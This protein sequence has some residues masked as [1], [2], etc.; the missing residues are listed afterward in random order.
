LSASFS[1]LPIP[2][3]SDGE[4]AL[5]D[6]VESAERSRGSGDRKETQL[7]LAGWR[8]PWMARQKIRPFRSATAA[9]NV[10]CLAAVLGSKPPL[11]SNEAASTAADGRDRQDDIGAATHRQ[12]P[13][14]DPIRYQRLTFESVRSHA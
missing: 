4:R 5:A 12:E 8:V 3:R 1:R 6:G 2:G 9:S 7:T 11:S 10:G 13:C 14:L